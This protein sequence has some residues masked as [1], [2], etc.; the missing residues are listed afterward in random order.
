M[1]TY[2]YVGLT[3]LATVIASRKWRAGVAWAIAV[4]VLQDPIRKLT[5]GA[6]A[7]M[8]LSSLPVWAAL[9]LKLRITERE[10]WRRLRTDCPSVA[11]RMAVFVVL[12]LPAAAVAFQYGLG[13]WRL[14][15]IGTLGYIAP[16]L[17]IFMGFAYVDRADRLRS[18]LV[19]YCVVTSA[20][21]AGSLCEYAGVLAS[22]PAIGTEALGMKWLR[23]PSAGGVFEMISGF[24][25]SP[26][27]MGWHAAALTMLSLTLAVAGGGRAVKWLPSAVLGAVCV[28]ISG[29]RKMIVMPAV[30]LGI[31]AAGYLRA[32]RTSR[33]SMVAGI[34]GLTL[35][36]LNVA[37]GQIAI[38]SDYYEY[39][40]S[41]REETAGRM[42]ISA[43]A[44]LWATLAQRGI[45]G[46][47]LGTA[48]QGTQHVM[49]EIQGSPRSWQESGLSKILIELGL[50][51]FLCALA[52]AAA[53]GRALLQS[54]GLFDAR[55]DT[56]LVGVVGFC[57]AN[58]AAFIVSHQVYG[59]LLVMTLTAF[60]IGVA[61]AA[62][63]WLPVK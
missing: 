61:L 22:W 32:G 10:T 54:L 7:I 37:A 42:W 58:A 30:W 1:A 62:R 21:M 38:R 49:E 57:V 46:A 52:L 33:V 60:F 14:V 59:D 50:P 20:M 23:Y 13:A 12:L 31:V 9:M 25:R 4:G 26:D 40:G 56:L 36:G 48:S 51:G 27:I 19:F 3:L 29:R 43:W 28:L 18:L 34:A 41:A 16:L 24:Y 15:V 39:A 53:I 45:L 6:P 47:G 17:G 2:L 35:V 8:A 63:R 5:P 44:D 11:R 55:Q